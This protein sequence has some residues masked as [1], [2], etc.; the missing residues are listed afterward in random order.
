MEEPP[1]DGVKDVQGWDYSND[2]REQQTVVEAVKYYQP[3][4]KK[5]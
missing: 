2:R 5:E 1:P 4:C 3:P